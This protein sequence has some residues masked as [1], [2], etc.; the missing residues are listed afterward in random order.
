M[1][2]SLIFAEE[3][4]EVE[5]STQGKWK[6]LI[7][8]DEP[9][10]HQV[11]RLVVSDFSFRN[12]SLELVSAYSAKE[13]K[14]ILTRP[15]NSDF[16]LAIVDVVMETNNAGLDLVSWIRNDLKSSKIRLVLR[17]G[18]PGEAP[19]ESVIRDYDLNDYK[20]K[21]ELT[22]LK[23]KTLF[24]SALR[25]YQDIVTIEQHRLGLEK[26]IYAS[27]KFI[28]CD[29]LPQ[30][31]STILKQVTLILG[32]ESHSIICCAATIKPDSNKQNLNI[33]AENNVLSDAS[34]QPDINDLPDEIRQRIETSLSQKRS[35]QT[36]QYF[37]GYFTTKRGTENSLYVS[38]VDKIDPT[39]HSLLE[40]FANSIAVAYENLSLRSVIKD[41]Q[42]EL[43]YVIGEA[44]EMRSKE[45]GS[46]VKR[47]AKFSYLLAML[48]G[49]PEAEA[50]MLKLASPLHDVGKVGIP[51]HI[52][53]KV[54]KHDQQ[55]WD[56]MQTHAQIGHEMLSKSKNPI[57]QKGAL[58][59]KQHHEKWDGS[60]YPLGLIGE[61]IDIVGRITA[62]ADVF[63]ALG[64]KRCYKA[65]WGKPEIEAFI[66]EQ[67][68]KHF[69]PR[70]VELMMENIDE[71]WAI[72]EKYPDEIYN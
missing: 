4:D 44:V 11:T 28:E 25:G 63:D 64:S 42:K 7:V 70:L 50:E 45:T 17:T 72:R 60:G 66:L 8:D 38:H 9:E 53:N 54:G 21:T 55:E 27:S 31:A 61:Q 5:I 26:I 71:F 20:N 35:I 46:H 67:K 13:A 47:V 33:L 34:N 52:L 69:D 68:G 15:E 39:Q 18:Q 32:L 29:T 14:E 10:I 43:S 59:A 49:M 6:V 57:L 62:I 22:A 23:L 51:D 36:E 40:F 1:G 12:K 16:A 48:H 41:S 19:E 56:V 3:K 30:F 24:Y 37:V 65:P 58:I 2:D